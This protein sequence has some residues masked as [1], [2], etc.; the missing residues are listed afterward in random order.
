MGRS[1]TQRPSIQPI[2]PF[3]I[4]SYEAL[5]RVA[6]PT[7][8]LCQ[9]CENRGGRCCERIQGTPHS[10]RGCTSD[11]HITDGSRPHPPPVP[12][13]GPM[14]FRTQMEV[15]RPM[16]SFVRRLAIAACVTAGLSPTIA[17]A[18]QP[19]VIS[20][21]VLTEAG[22]PIQSA[23]VVITGLN[24]GTYSDVEGAFRVSVP[25]DKADGVVTVTARRVGYQPRS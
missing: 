22:A 16:T 7:S 10:D 14:L 23:S 17:R 1:S 5:G 21:R 19:A 3:P 11:V 9:V 6:R 12:S 4:E 13:D 2:C 18:Q 8:R 24:L 15:N 20:G 25:A